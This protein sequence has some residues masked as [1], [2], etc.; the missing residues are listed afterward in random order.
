MY[1]QS[2]ILEGGEQSIW[3]EARTITKQYVCGIP[4]CSCPKCSQIQTGVSPYLQSYGGASLTP[5]DVRRA[6]A[7]TTRRYGSHRSILILGTTQVNQRAADMILKLS[8]EPPENT[9]IMI[10][11]TSQWNLPTTI[12]SRCSIKRLPGAVAGQSAAALLG[13]DFLSL[14]EILSKWRRTNVLRSRIVDAV[15]EM[16]L[17]GEY[18]LAYQIGTELLESVDDGAL[19]MGLILSLG[20]QNSASS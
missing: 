17:L 15:R 13:Q 2:V 8:E 11:V 10:G 6:V 4:G 5:D 20:K 3:A 18:E 12:L 16:W 1:H 7:S 14:V 9:L 19:Q